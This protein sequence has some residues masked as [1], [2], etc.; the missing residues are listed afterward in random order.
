M[1]QAPSRTVRA[2]AR[3]L[4]AACAALLVAPLGLGCSAYGDAS[5]EMLLGPQA[6][7]VAAAGAS[8]T[9]TVTFTGAWT[10]EA[11]P[12]GVP[13]GAH[14]S[15]LI[16][17][18][19]NADVAFLEA[20]GTATPGIESMAER[21]RTA[22]LTEEIQAAGANA[23]S[24]LRKDSGPGATA[25]DTFEAVTV[26]AD[27]PRITLLSMIAPSP[28]WFVGV[29]GLSLLDAEGNW[30]DAL[31]VNLYPWDAGTEGGDDF[32]FN[33]AATV[34][35][36]TIVSLRGEGRFSDAPIATMTFTLQSGA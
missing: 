33:N 23:L 22:T 13:D 34:P 24:V 36:G 14:F 4:V 3:F 25:S 21:G 32:S 18:V 30:A 27:H 9:Y 10:A 1:N 2:G 31:T 7:E 26:T 17:G 29:F 35:P 8:A 28:D 6:G 19:H 5:D 15:P 11:T 16:G 12:G 20:G